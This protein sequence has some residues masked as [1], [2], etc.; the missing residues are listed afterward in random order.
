MGP[1]IEL[2]PYCV[3]GD[4]LVNLPEL[5]QQ[6]QS[7]SNSNSHC[8]HTFVYCIMSAGT[9][10]YCMAFGA[11][12]EVAIHLRSGFSGQIHRRPSCLVDC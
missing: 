12:M 2:S 5:L 3:S 9:C 6:S 7:Q 1:T 8:A 10:V 4:L 11:V